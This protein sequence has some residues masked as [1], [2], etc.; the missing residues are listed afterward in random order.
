MP[1]TEGEPTPDDRGSPARTPPRGP[2]RPPGAVWTRDPGRGVPDPAGSGGGG[3]RGGGHPADRAR[4]RR[5]APG[6]GEAAAVAPAHRDEPG[7]RRSA[8]IVRASSS[9]TS[10]RTGPRAGPTRTSASRCSPAWI[11]S[12]RARVLPWCSATTLTCQY[13]DGRGPRDQREHGQDPAPRGPGADA[14]DPRR[15]RRRRGRPPM[16]DELDPR[17]EARL[18]DALHHEADTLPFTL[19]ARGPGAGP[20]GTGIHQDPAAHPGLAARGSRRHRDPRRWRGGMEE[21]RTAARRQRRRRTRGPPSWSRMRIS[22]RACPR[23]AAR[24]CWRRARTSPAPRP[25]QAPRRR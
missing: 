19:R 4:S 16:A 12:R 22:R 21:R 10:C 13:G 3:G 25:A 18:R 8:V 23:R 5:P 14:P 11:G 2:R 24:S 1:P 9:S 17:L 15:G 7:A 6:P 20:P